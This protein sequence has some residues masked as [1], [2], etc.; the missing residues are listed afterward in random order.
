MVN[1][2]YTVGLYYAKRSY[3]LAGFAVEYRYKM[4]S[5]YAVHDSQRTGIWNT[6]HEY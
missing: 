5:K 6:N 2:S 1:I 3:H 4:A